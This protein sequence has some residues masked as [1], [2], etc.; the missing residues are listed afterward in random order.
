MFVAVSVCRR[1]V[2]SNLIQHNTIYVIKSPFLIYLESVC[3]DDDETM[4]MTMVIMIIIM[5]IMTLLLFMA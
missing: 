1:R 4:V 2:G 3:H 5:V